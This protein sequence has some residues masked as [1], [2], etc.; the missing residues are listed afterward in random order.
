MI[1]FND[2]T[3]FDFLAFFLDRGSVRQSNRGGA[4]AKMREAFRV[5]FFRQLRL[6]TRK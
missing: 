1:P 5:A 6:I 4:K 3:R 2:K